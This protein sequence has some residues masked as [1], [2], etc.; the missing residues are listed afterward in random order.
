MSGHRPTLL[1]QCG[2]M[3]PSAEVVDLNLI[4]LAIALYRLGRAIGADVGRR[5]DMLERVAPRA[6][7][8]RR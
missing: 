4:R 6:H 5:A 1:H 3:R 2:T 8:A 7:E